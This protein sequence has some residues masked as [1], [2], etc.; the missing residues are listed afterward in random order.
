MKF[1]TDKIDGQK[2]LNVTGTSDW[3]RS[4]QGGENIE[5]NA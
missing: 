3:A 2:L 4:G 1:I 5:A